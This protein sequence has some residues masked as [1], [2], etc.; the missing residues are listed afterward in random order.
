MDMKELD[1]AADD[2]ANALKIIGPITHEDLIIMYRQGAL[3][4][5][6]QIQLNALESCVVEKLTFCR[7][8]F[9]HSGK[10]GEQCPNCGVQF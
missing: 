5:C 8:C 6:K 9:R 1:E 7:G 10:A 2:C 4:A 3:W